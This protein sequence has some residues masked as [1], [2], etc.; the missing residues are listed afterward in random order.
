M[1]AMFTCLDS[2]SEHVDLMTTLPIIPSLI[3]IN[4]Y[5]PHLPLA[6]IA[7]LVAYNI[8]QPLADWISYSLLG[9]G[10]DSRL[11]DIAGIFPL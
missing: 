4:A 8:I 9:L 6:V 2:R 10:A 7:W 1:S 5:L 3:Q 11:G